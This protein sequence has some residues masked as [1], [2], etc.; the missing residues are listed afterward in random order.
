MWAGFL[1]S[2][3]SADG[4]DRSNFPFIDLLARLTPIHLR[5]FPSSAIEPSKRSPLAGSGAALD[6]YSTA[7]ELM[8]AAD[9]HSFPRIQ[10]TIGQL[11][12]VGL[13]AET[14]RPSYVK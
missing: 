2:S 8:E 6:L 1:V 5:I 11:A 14:A 13:L 9:S 3:C 7:A 12:S 4:Q 10:Q